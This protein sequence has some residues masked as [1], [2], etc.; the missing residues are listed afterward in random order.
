[1]TPAMP[2]AREARDVRF[3]PNV[4]PVEAV[5]IEVGGC[6]FLFPRAIEARVA[7]VIQGKYDH[8][9]LPD[10][11]KVRR[12]IDIGAA[13]G[14]F[15][16]WAWTRWPNVWVD[17]YEA[18]D[19]H[20]AFLRNNLPPGAAIV[21]TSVP[22]QASAC[23]LPPCDVLRLDMNGGEADVIR[24]YP[25][26]PNVVCFDWHLHKDRLEIEGT[27]SS[28]GLRCFHLFFKNPDLGHQVWVRSRAKWSEEKKGY[29]LP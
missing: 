10:A 1:M 29:E 9:K 7:Q 25:H 16:C 3:N 17:C 18:S 22:D 15:A 11:P 13:V 5:R 28:W 24:G 8:P 6:P 27:L 2:A 4:T 14:E 23:K 21:G 19:A 12:I 20:R 26:R